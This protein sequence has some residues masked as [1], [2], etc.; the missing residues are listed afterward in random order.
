DLQNELSP[1]QTAHLPN[2]LAPN[3]PHWENPQTPIPK[4]ICHYYDP[5]QIHRDHKNAPPPS[6]DLRSH[7]RAFAYNRPHNVY[8]YYKPARSSSGKHYDHQWNA[9]HLQRSD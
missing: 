9:P 6:V 3:W 5:T 7:P 1:L 8:W 4:G 2:P